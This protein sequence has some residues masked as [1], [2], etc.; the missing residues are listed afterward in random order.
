MTVQQSLKNEHYPENFIFSQSE[1]NAKTKIFDNIFT[2]I[3][4]KPSFLQKI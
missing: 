3:F 4:G 1:D 2:R